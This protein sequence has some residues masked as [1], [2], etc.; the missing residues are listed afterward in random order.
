M[1]ENELSYKIIGVALQLHSTLG[2]G[3]LE[4]A[5]E[6]ALAYDLIKSGFVVQRQ[7][8]MPMIY[9]EIQM[10]IGYRIDLM[11]DH[12]VIIELKS[13]EKLAPVHFAQTL[14]YLKLAGLKLALLINFNSRYLKD[15][16]HRIVNN[17]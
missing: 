5:Y 9:K 1:N 11:I 15:G 2:P 8:P 17:L 3:L 13:I 16:I 4:S 6:E 7:L 12:K 14:T 10:D